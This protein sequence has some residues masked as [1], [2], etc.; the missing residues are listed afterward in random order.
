MIRSFPL[1]QEKRLAIYRYLANRIFNIKE[2]NDKKCTIVDKIF[3]DYIAPYKEIMDKLPESF[4]IQ[5]SSF[6]CSILNKDR[7]VCAWS[8]P[9][10]IRPT[11]LTLSKAR[12]MP[13]SL[14]C[15][16]SEL[17]INE[18]NEYFKEF[19]TLVMTDKALQQKVDENKD[20][21]MA[22]LNSA[23]TSQ[24]LVKI[25]PELEPILLQLFPNECIDVKKKSLPMKVYDFTLPGN[26]NKTFGLP[27]SEENKSGCA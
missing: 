17:I 13:Y 14:A 19:Y 27:I 25:W 20:K 12:V 15:I 7:I 21:T 22:V 5:S 18:D 3:E 23:N 10:S 16:Y 4:F 6:K 1:S 8:K 24:Q 9:D 11:Q 26:L 2:Y